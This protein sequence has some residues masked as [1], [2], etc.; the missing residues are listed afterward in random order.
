M[1]LNL[2]ASALWV[3]PKSLDLINEI[4]VS[5]FSSKLAVGVPSIDYKGFFLV[6]T[7]IVLD[8]VK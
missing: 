5:T 4:K 7:Y 8:I 2:A 6:Y 3:K 1:L